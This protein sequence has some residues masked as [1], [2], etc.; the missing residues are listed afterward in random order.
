MSRAQPFGPAPGAIERA[1][2]WG[3]ALAHFG[4]GL[5][6]VADDDAQRLRRERAG[7]RQHVGD[8]RPAGQRVQRLGQRGVHALSLTG[9]EHDYSEVHRGGF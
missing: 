2:E 1:Q 6:A 3:E 4:R 9:G 8:E 5:A 7:R